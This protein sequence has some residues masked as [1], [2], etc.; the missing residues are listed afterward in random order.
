MPDRY[1]N[2][3]IDSVTG[4]PCPHIS[5]VGKCSSPIDIDQCE[6]IDA[7]E[8]GLQADLSIAD[9]STS[10]QFINS[11]SFET[12]VNLLEASYFL[13]SKNETSMLHKFEFVTKLAVRNVPI[14]R[15][16]RARTDEE[17]ADDGIQVIGPFPE[18]SGGNFKKVDPEFTSQFFKSFVDRKNSDKGPRR[19]DVA[20]FVKNVGRS[21]LN[22]IDV[23]RETE[24]FCSDRS[25]R[26]SR[27]RRT[28]FGKESKKSMNPMVAMQMLVRGNIKNYGSKTIEIKNATEASFLRENYEFSSNMYKFI[29]SDNEEDVISA[30]YGADDKPRHFHSKVEAKKFVDEVAEA[31]LGYQGIPADGPRDLATGKKTYTDTQKVRFKL[32]EFAHTLNKDGTFSFKAPRTQPSYDSREVMKTFNEEAIK[33][34]VEAK[35]HVEKTNQPFFMYCAYRAPHRPFSH[36]E[37]Y[38]YTRPGSFIGKAGEQLREFDDRIG[39]MMKTLE[40]LNLADNTFVMFTSDNGPDGS[41]FANQD[42]AGHVRFATFRGKKASVYEGGH[43]VPFLVWWPKGI[44]QEI[45]GS[46]YDLP[47]S[48]LDLFSTFADMIQYPLPT[49]DKCTYAYDSESEPIKSNRVSRSLS[50]IRREVDIP[51]GAG[52]NDENAVYLISTLKQKC[53]GRLSGFNVESCPCDNWTNENHPDFDQSTADICL[54]RQGSYSDANNLEVC[55]CRPLTKDCPDGFCYSRIQFSSMKED[56]MNIAGGRDTINN[57]FYKTGNN[58]K[59]KYVGLWDEMSST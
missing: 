39:L 37:E 31:F 48:Q 41:G 25:R 13:M 50:E 6:W 22:R 7:L 57:L 27:S 54:W 59:A 21:M 30:P 47:V 26:E 1:T 20:E 32:W 10:S 24:I 36:I 3:Q 34:F 15:F 53:D 4:R 49:A 44:N 8:S 12:L 28:I 51:N 29:Y 18:N 16:R 46:N 33:N 23:I 55:Q 42:Y 11:D 9:S 38:D 19:N 40:D 45:W 43:R 17:K 52:R 58:G 5:D 56:M 14:N 35:H 2:L